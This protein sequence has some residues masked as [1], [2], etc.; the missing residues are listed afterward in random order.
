MNP[1][2]QL[3]FCDQPYRVALEPKTESPRIH[4]CSNRPR[5]YY[6]RVHIMV[7][8]LPKKISRESENEP[9]RINTV[10]HRISCVYTEFGRGLGHKLSEGTPQRPHKGIKVKIETEKCIRFRF[11]YVHWRVNR[12]TN[13]EKINFTYRKRGT[14]GTGRVVK[15]DMYPLDSPIV[16]QKTRHHGP[17]FIPRERVTI[18]PRR[19]PFKGP[20]TRRAKMGPS[21]SGEER[22]SQRFVLGTG[23]RTVPE[24]VWARSNFDVPI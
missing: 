12:S 9:M 6:A 2:Q 13:A 11:E 18:G 22:G 20:T 14:K 19:C 21:S 4:D 10:H 16:D 17:Q 5:L 7:D 23:T 3:G 24:K 15:G 1:A 8:H